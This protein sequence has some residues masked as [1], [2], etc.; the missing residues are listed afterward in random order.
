M[1]DPERYWDCMD[2]AFECSSSGRL[3]EA[4]RWLDEAL[5]VNP[6]GAEA[7]NGRGEILWDHLD[8]MPGQRRKRRQEALRDFSRAIELDAGYFPAH[9]NRI[10][11]LIEE[12]QRFDHAVGLADELLTGALDSGTEAEAWYLKAKALF[13]LDDLDGALFL[14][15]RAIKAHAEVAIYRGFEGQI[16][17]ELGQFEA[18]QHSL[19]RA[20]ALEPECAHSVYHL[21]LVSEHL[22]LREESERLFGEAANLAPDMYPLPVRMELED[23]E[24]AAE[25][26]LAEL[27]EEIRRYTANCPVIIE[28]LP[29]VELVREHNLSPQILGLFLG[30]PITEPGANPMQ[31]T[32]LKLDVDRILLFKRNLEKVASTHEELVEQIAITVKHEIGHCLGFD[33]DEIE[34]LGL[35]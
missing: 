20:L 32:S 5:R 16:L 33:E 26:A 4:L 25:D 30:V 3:E 15:K 14:L 2:Q 19:E 21:A 17:F 31:S 11:I 23:F 35:G 28:D 13:Y 24:E 10:E 7:Y 27:P 8:R 9:L 22:G 34:R 12:F 18:A 1:V 29:D 6:N